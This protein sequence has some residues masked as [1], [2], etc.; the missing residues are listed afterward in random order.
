MSQREQESSWNQ[1]ADFLETLNKALPVKSATLLDYLVNVRVLP[2]VLLQL[3]QIGTVLMFLVDIEVLPVPVWLFPLAAFGLAVSLVALWYRGATASGFATACATFCTATAVALEL[4]PLAQAGL[5]IAPYLFIVFAST[6]RDQDAF[7]LGPSL[8]YSIFLLTAPLDGELSLGGFATS[9][10]IVVICLWYFIRNHHVAQLGYILFVSDMV[11]RTIDSFPV[12]VC[13]C[14]LN[15][16][17]L[18]YYCCS[19]LSQSNSYVANFAYLALPCWLLHN[20]VNS[21]FLPTILGVYSNL[22]EE[23]LFWLGESFWLLPLVIFFV[24]ALA[25]FGR[26]LLVPILGWIQISALVT[27]F[28]FGVFFERYNFNIWFLSVATAFL[29]ML[30]CFIWLNPQR[31]N[32]MFVL[33]TSSVL[34]Y[35][36][37]ALY[38]ASDHWN[39]MAVQYIGSQPR[40][41]LIDPG[42]P[43]LFRFQWNFGSLPWTSALGATAALL[44]MALYGIR[45]GQS[46]TPWWRGIA[47]PRFVV[48]VRRVW[49]LVDVSIEAT[50]LI[51]PL[52]SVYNRLRDTCSLLKTESKPVT[53]ID[54]IFVAFTLVAVETAIV[55]LDSMYA[56]GPPYSLHIYS[57][58]KNVPDFHVAEFVGPEELPVVNLVIW[59]AGGI[60]IYLFGMIIRQTLL[61]YLGTVFLFIPVMKVFFAGPYLRLIGEGLF[62]AGVALVFCSAARRWYQ[63]TGF[64]AARPPSQKKRSPRFRI[65]WFMWSVSRSTPGGPEC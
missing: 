61:I 30:A 47:R 23:A 19:T 25:Y 17:L 3:A 16:L 56:F 43:S 6:R 60:I 35:L 37:F 45:R 1:A 57:V 42:L 54:I 18:I 33:I 14:T 51:G 50:T 41:T 52:L 53:L 58:S 27:L 24:W 9:F 38:R 48:L 28:G 32:S 26:Y 15:F 22:S 20:T 13:L 55:N 46:E 2:I 34:L 59:T 40:E 12:T 36:I 49:S 62:V 64:G 31:Y 21:L 29:A 65:T 44:A 5:T 7:G 63:A 39:K 4:D 8:L 10:S 11:T